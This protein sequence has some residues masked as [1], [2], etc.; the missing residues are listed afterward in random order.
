MGKMT[1]LAGRTFQAEL[2]V[3]PDKMKLTKGP[4]NWAA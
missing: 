3:N 2:P 1:M 4:N